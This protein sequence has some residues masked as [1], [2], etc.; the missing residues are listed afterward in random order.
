MTNIEK[1][2]EVFGFMPRINA[3]LGPSK[4]CREHELCDDCPFNGWFEKEFKPCFKIKDE[5]E[6]E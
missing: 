1:F 6:E 2:K 5:Y 3:C 4:V